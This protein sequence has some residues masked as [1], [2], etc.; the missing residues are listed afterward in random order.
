MNSFKIVAHYIEGKDDKTKLHFIKSKALQNII[1]LSI[2]L[3][4]RRC[5]LRVPTSG[6]DAAVKFTTGNIPKMEERQVNEDY[7]GQVWCE[8]IKIFNISIL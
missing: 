4:S 1:K 6:N 8:N 2:A 3:L 5:I 7:G